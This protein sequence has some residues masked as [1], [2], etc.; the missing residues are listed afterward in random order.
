MEGKKTN[1]LEEKILYLSP[2]PHVKSGES[3]PRIMWTVVITLMPATI[4]GVY[5]FGIRALWVILV[6][7]ATAVITEASIQ[8]MRRK[9]I[10]VYNGSAVITGLLLALCLPPSIPYYAVIIGT[11]FGIAVG[12]HAF[13][14]LGYNIFNPALIGRAFLQASFPVKMTTWTPTLLQQKCVDAVTTATPLGLFKFE[15]VTTPYVDLL[16]GNVGGCIGETCAIAII[17]GGIIL[18]VLRYADW[19]IPLSYLG[20]VA[21]LGGIFWLINPEQYPDPLF[22]LLAGGLMLGAFFMAT[23]MVTSP[24]TPLGSW[25]FG[26]GAGTLLIIIRLFGG[27]PE[28]VMY[29]IILMNSVTPLINM[30]TRP[31]ILGEKK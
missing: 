10:T 4:M 20:T 6:S 8:L 27:L 1:K 30:F 24:S 12:K 9:K 2:S 19:R 14:G 26:I 25:I 15:K 7:I 17:A 22:H 18:L 23:D 28:G 11:F 16:W 5:F 31:K 3:V 21:I 29:S 13:G